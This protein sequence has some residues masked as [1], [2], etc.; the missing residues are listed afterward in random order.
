MTEPRGRDA[1]S[2]GDPGQLRQE[3]ESLERERDRLRGEV[4]RLHGPSAP[5][6]LRAIAAVALVVVSVVAFAAAVP[7]TWTRR[8]VLNTDRYVEYT[9]QIAAEPA[10]QQRLA[11]RITDAAFEA[12]DVEARLRSALSGVRTELGF[13]AGPITQAVH[14][15]I[16]SRVEQ[17]LASETFQRLWAEANRVAHAQI[18]AVL[19]GDSEAVR[20]VDGKVVLNTLPIV[21]E[22]LKDLT[23]LVSDLVGRPVQMPEITATTVP[24]EAITQIESALGVDLPDNLGAIEIY[25]ANEIEAVQQAVNL[26][27][28][29][30]VLVV[31][32]WVLTFAAALLVSQR[33]RR[34]LLQLLVASTIVLVLERRFAIA[35]VDSVVAGLAPEARAA[36][37]AIADVL[38]GGLLRYT[39]WLLWIAVL[40]SAMA[41][42]TGPYGW[43]TRMR[44]GVVDVVAAAVGA[45]RGTQAGP[46]ARWVASRRDPLM[47]AGAALFVLVLL[48][49]DVGIAGFLLLIAILALF[50][51]AVWRTAAA[52]APP[53]LA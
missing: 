23:G 25:D 16:R 24:S 29:A 48:V 40:A 34:T 47:L 41:L 44:S 31:V 3:I 38:L 51:L 11:A 42:V 37:R 2:G 4:D 17:L 9:S 45:V 12:L 30:V 46:T 18:L 32:L 26:F 15:R 39:K 49:V 6:R 5:R 43:A 21:N 35:T 14:E 28:R 50:E 7:G 33:R 36:G 53:A 22:T 10:V 20:I 19:G 1:M 27:D 52:L 13:L 8:T